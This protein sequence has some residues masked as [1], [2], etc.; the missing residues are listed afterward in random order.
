MAELRSIYSFIHSFSRYLLSFYYV[1]VVS[2]I[3]VLVRAKRVI[4][5]VA[6]RLLW[7]SSSIRSESRV[8]KGGFSYSCSLPSL[9]ALTPNSVLISLHY[10]LQKTHKLNKHCFQV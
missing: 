1:P 8:D 4:L 7:S 3:T 6:L 2:N 9:P 10:P 5:E